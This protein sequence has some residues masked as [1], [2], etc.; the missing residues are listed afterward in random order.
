M[1]RLVTFTVIAA[2]TPGPREL[3][4]DPEDN[5]SGHALNP[6]S[7]VNRTVPPV[8]FVP[9]SI[10]SSDGLLIMVMILAIPIEVML[11]IVRMIEIL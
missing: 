9:A 5:R 1:V 10:V 6:D 2:T 4:V 3:P 11:I 8:D 7:L